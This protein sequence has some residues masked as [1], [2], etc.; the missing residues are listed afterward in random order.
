M[1]ATI[2]LK[3]YNGQLMGGKGS[4]LLPLHGYA[5]ADTQNDDLTFASKILNRL[6][7]FSDAQYNLAFLMHAAFDI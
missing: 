1:V 5:T 3:Y 2:Y 6:Y 4:N 7:F